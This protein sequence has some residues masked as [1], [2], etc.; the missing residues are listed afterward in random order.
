MSTLTD[1]SLRRRTFAIISYPAAGKTALAQKLLLFGGA[2]QGPA[3]DAAGSVSR[4]TL[5]AH[6][7]MVNFATREC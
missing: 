6:G 3:T 7:Y 1:E 4:F 5:Q 2:I